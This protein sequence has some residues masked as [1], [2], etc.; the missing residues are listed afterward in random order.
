MTPWAV[1]DWRRRFPDQ[2]K[3][4][5]DEEIA[6]AILTANPSWATLYPELKAFSD[7]NQSKREMRRGAG[8]DKRGAASA[9]RKSIDP[10]TERSWAEAF[11][12]PFKRG[13]LMAQ[14][15][16][17][18]T[19]LSSLKI[20][21]N[22]TRE[23]VAKMV[24]IRNKFDEI[25]EN[26]HVKEFNEA[27]GFME[28]A[29]EFLGWSETFAITYEW[30]ASSLA[31][32]VSHGWDNIAGG[33]AG[34]AAVGAAGGAIGGPLAGF[35]GTA[36]ALYG[37]AAGMGK[38]SNDL[39][40]AGKFLEMWEEVVGP[41]VMGNPDL[42]FKA[43]QDPETMKMARSKAAKYGIPIG[44]IDGITMGVAGKVLGVGTKLA[45]HAS[46]KAAK[47]P[48]QS[49]LNRAH[50]MAWL[51]TEKLAPVAVPTGVESVMGGLGEVS[52]QLMSEGKVKD[53]KAVFAE[54]VAE[55][56]MAPISITAAHLT[57][58]KSPEMAK[59]INDRV[60]AFRDKGMSLDDQ[61]GQV[62]TD[63]AAGQYTTEQR[64]VLKGHV[65]EVYDAEH[66]NVTPESEIGAKV[67]MHIKDARLEIL[68][69]MGAADL[70]DVKVALTELSETTRADSKLAVSKDRATLE[71]WERAVG[72][73]DIEARN[74]LIESGDVEIVKPPKDVKEFIKRMPATLI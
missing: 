10:N 34:G 74:E 38:T 68:K 6:A 61:L 57:K 59:A 26:P 65:R 43:M 58:D 70:E 11:K 1:D 55:V 42:L 20:K 8:Y 39:A 47:I 60:R 54:A 32:Q 71:K 48:T 52:G 25:R 69:A 51:G 30:I 16:E 22:I 66:R 35:T 36:G 64:D 31:G 13:L 56:G 49:L 41:E 4:R 2:T 17:L 7:L 23:D 40:Q 63:A 28:S 21:G 19:S 29:G 46:R 62:D 15:A 14:Q 18:L 9:H 72:S 73:S 67:G 27:R 3:G 12:D 37:A 24:R 53:W 5:S 33:A 50:K 44:I 45:A